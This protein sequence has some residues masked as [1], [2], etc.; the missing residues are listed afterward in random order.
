MLVV[1]VYMANGLPEL[2][3]NLVNVLQLVN[4]IRSHNGPFI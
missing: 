2:G 3:E 1:M 4:L